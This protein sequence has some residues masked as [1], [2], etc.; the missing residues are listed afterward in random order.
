MP[1]H[2]LGRA[3]ESLEILR[4]AL[5]LATDW[6]SE[7]WIVGL[8][9]FAARPFVHHEVAAA[10]FDGVLEAA[11]G[12]DEIEKLFGLLGSTHGE[13]KPAELPNELV[14]YALEAFI[15]WA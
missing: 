5:I 2:R 3:L 4:D 7:M 8:G 13:P 15:A 6:K 10:R 14:G 11:H 1:S 9:G 12:F